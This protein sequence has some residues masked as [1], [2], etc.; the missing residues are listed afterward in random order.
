MKKQ[1]LITILNRK[2]QSIDRH[3]E[4]IHY[5]P[6]FHDYVRYLGGEKE[7]IP[8]VFNKLVK[9]KKITLDDLIYFTGIYFISNPDFESEE[10]KAKPFFI[11]K[12][13]QNEF[14]FYQKALEYWEKEGIKI[15]RHLKSTKPNIPVKVNKGNKETLIFDLDILH[16]S[17]LDVLQS[18]TIINWNYR[19]NQLII[20]GNVVFDYASNTN[21]H[22]LL[23]A[24][25]KI[26]EERKSAKSEDKEIFYDEISDLR[27]EEYSKQFEKM[28]Y[29]ACRRIKNK[30]L[31]SNYPVFFTYNT[32][33]IVLTVE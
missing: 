3:K 25:C 14:S 31:A 17:I 28:M 29:Q 22:I 19:N 1:D 8:K 26:Y 15:N 33:E 16:N 4:L 5:F 6:F 9:D 24:L 30:L 27:N 18:D 7:Y 32:K 2:F 13:I 20:D 11:T 23:D 10:N 21:E 12:Y